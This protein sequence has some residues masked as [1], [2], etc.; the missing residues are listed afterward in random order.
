MSLAPRRRALTIRRVG[1]WSKTRRTLRSLTRTAPEL[2][3]VIYQQ[4]KRSRDRLKRNIRAQAY[5]WP[6]LDQDYAR[7]KA[8]AGLDPRTMIAHGDY[9][10]AIRVLPLGPLTWGVGIEEGATNREG[11]SLVMIG[12]SAEYGLGRNPARP[13]WRREYGVFKG[14]L[15][16]ALG[17]ALGQKVNLRD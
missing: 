10:D 8:A 15:S 16:R 4:A 5:P 2:S 13:H 1:D 6:P 11:D 3:A 7:E 14:Q 9:L 17:T 12:L